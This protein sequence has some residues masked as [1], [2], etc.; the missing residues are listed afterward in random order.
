MEKK[1]TRFNWHNAFGQVLKH[2]WTPLGLQVIPEYEVAKNPMKVDVVVIRQGSALSKQALTKLPD[3]V[4]NYLNDHNLID[5]KSIHES[6]GYDELEKTDLYAKLYREQEEIAREQLS[7][8]AV[9][10]KIPQGLLAKIP[11][12]IKREAKGIYQVRLSFLTIILLV[13]NE[14]EDKEANDVFEL[15]A[16]QKNYYLRSIQRMIGNPFWQSFRGIVHIF[17]QRLGKELSMA[18]LTLEQLEERTVLAFMEQATAEEFAKVVEKIPNKIDVLEKVVNQ[19]SREER[20][21]LLR[22]LQSD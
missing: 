8:F 5:F 22:K 13:P 20:A 6:Y 12:W 3:G 15:F 10:S 9:S 7:V 21:L 16:S 11:D 1:K 4:R 17:T 18:G 19:M 14:M 2:G